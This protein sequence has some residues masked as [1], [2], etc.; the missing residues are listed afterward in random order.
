MLFP[1]DDQEN[2]TF[3]LESVVEAAC[4]FADSTPLIWQT[5]RLK[6]KREQASVFLWERVIDLIMW[7]YQ[8]LLFCQTE[9]LM[10]ETSAVWG[11]KL[12]PENTSSLLWESKNHSSSW[13]CFQTAP[14]SL[15]RQHF[16]SN[17]KEM[18]Y[19]FSLNHFIFSEVLL[20]W[21]NPAEP[22]GVVTALPVKL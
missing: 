4:V 21:L 15:I 22:P 10:F 9:D 7:R 1:W 3:H 16:E 13:L 8:H 12:R 18:N 20:V 17:Q 2:L 19:L 5:L 11:E 6:N 14:R